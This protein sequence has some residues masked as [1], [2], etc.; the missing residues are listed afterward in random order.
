MNLKLR[1]SKMSDEKINII[2]NDSFIDF[3]IELWRLSKM[4]DKMI[5][6]MDMNE[7]N[8]YKSQYAWFNKKTIEF[9]NNENISINSLEGMPFDAGMPVT[10][11][12]IGEFKK[13]DELVIEQT[14]EPIIMQNGKLIK[15]GSVLLKKVEK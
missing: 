8:R 14:L 5:I 12:N 15:S 3:I 13:D 6:K 11:I 9:L 2:I 10:P 7:Q 4:F 1:E